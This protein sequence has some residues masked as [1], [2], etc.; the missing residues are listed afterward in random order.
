MAWSIRSYF[1]TQR[2]VF[3]G[4]LTIVIITRLIIYLWLNYHGYFYG[5]P[6]DSFSR[7]LLSF[8]WAQNPYFAP[9]DG[10]WLPLQFWVVGSVYVLTHHW[11]PTSN[12]MVPVFVNNLFFIGSLLIIYKFC[13]KITGKVSISFIAC[14]IASFF[15]GDIFVTYT[16]LSEPI[17]IFLILL[18]CYQ[19]YTLFTGGLQ[20]S[21]A[22]PLFLSITGLFAS[23]THYIGWFLSLF[24]VLSLVPHLLK[25]IQKR[26]ISQIFYLIFCIIICVIMPFLWLLNNYLTWGNPLHP[27]QFAK[28]MQAGYI[29]QLSFIARF[30]VTPE[31]ILKQ[32]YPLIIP[33]VFAFVL[34]AI[35]KPKILIFMVPAI[36]VLSLIWLSTWFALK[37]SIS[38]T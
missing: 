17:L 20:K 19:F 13:S 1:H 35:K 38:R 26:D 3:W 11:D 2:F 33:G 22:L 6:W 29:G 31:V 37:C 7:T 18:A 10:Y 16:A 12:I 5:I 9:S 24:I 34:V 30:L 36:F 25:S 15:A 8:D 21:R 27:I 4:S 28:Q 23:A 32:F 14:L